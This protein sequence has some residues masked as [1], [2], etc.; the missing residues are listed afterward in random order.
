M[1]YK[2]LGQRGKV[3][4]VY[5]KLKALNPQFAEEFFKKAVLP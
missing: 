2:K 4:E 3:I 5:E 1:L